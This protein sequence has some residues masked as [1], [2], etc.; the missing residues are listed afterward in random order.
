MKP[1]AYL[2]SSHFSYCTLALPQLLKSMREAGVP[3]EDIFVVLS[4]CKREFE[5]VGPDCTFWYV[6][7]ESR[8]FATYVEAVNPW[9][10]NALER[11]DHM[12][13]LTDTCLVLPDFYKLSMTFNRNLDAVGATPFMGPQLA[14]TE[15]G[16]YKLDYL[17]GRAPMIN[18]IYRNVTH[19][20]N[21]DYEGRMF[22][23]ADPAKRAFYS[24]TNDEKC[25]VINGP[26]D[27]Y[28]TGTPRITE[29]YT[30]VELLHFKSN[31]GQHGRKLLDTI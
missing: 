1:I 17:H 28:G 14:Q 7:H 4:G 15:F 31:W 20:D 13:H 6:G 18:K 11:F 9:R 2:I 29:R 27:I 23:L 30:A 19:D 12:F 5:Q 21:V 16:A 26:M 8:N 3:K 10:H 24:G 22:G 25:V